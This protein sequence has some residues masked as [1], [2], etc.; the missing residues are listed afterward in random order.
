MNTYKV[1]RHI[2][3]DVIVHAHN[4]QEALLKAGTQNPDTL[5]VTRVSISKIR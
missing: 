5:K 3:Q 2:I 4:K 1:R